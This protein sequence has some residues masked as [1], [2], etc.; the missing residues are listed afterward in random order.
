ME[1][2]IVTAYVAG[3]IGILQF[4]LM[5]AVGLARGPAG[6][7]LGDG[8]NETLQRNIRRHGNL[9]ENAPI[10]ILLLGL[11]ELAGGNATYVLYL[12][13]LFVVARLAHALA[14]SGVAAGVLRPVGAFGT[15]ISGV[16]S[17]V[18]LLLAVQAM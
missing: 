5:M 14:L 18:L 10:F 3:L 17:A 4:A 7:S 13:A 2:P 11:L 1:F 9:T 15:L 6:V 16:G 8:G 12:G